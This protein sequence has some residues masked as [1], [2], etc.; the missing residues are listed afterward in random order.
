MS[1]SV[2]LM[3]CGVCFREWY[4]NG[5]YLVLLVSLVI[6][7]PLSLLRNLGKDVQEVCFV[8]V[9]LNDRL[10]DVLKFHLS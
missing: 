3:T 1:L 2:Y 5:D 7:V 4:V 8:A 6:I 9:Y 10:M